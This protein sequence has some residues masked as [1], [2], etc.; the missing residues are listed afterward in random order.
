MSWILRE[1]R[2]PALQAR[3]RGEHDAQRAQVLGL[4]GP[5]IGD[6]M[7]PPGTRYAIANGDICLPRS[8]NL[9]PRQVVGALARSRDEAS[10]ALPARRASEHHDSHHDS[11]GP[12]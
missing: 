6:G 2:M 3:L 5:C 7:V 9:Q 8:A 4:A 1:S 10:D 11:A 12:R